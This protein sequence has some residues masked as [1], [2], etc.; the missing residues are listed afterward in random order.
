MDKQMEKR[1]KELMKEPIAIVPYDPQWA[2]RYADL[3][4]QLKRMIPRMLAQRITHIGSTAVPGLRSKPVVDVQVEVSDLEAV[5][6]ELAPRMEEAGYEFIWRPTMGDE[7]PFYAWFI[8]R[9]ASGE[10]M[11]HVHM[12]EP[13]QASVDRIVFRDYLR[14]HPE[15]VEVYASL[16]E[17]L[18][19]TFKRDRQA[20]TRGKTD[21]VNATLQK[22]RQEKFK[23]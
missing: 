17:D 3:E 20:Y 9:D 10:R 21:Y 5:R 6:N 4:T 18:A 2:V 7:A 1:I 12:V 16:K 23:R 15:E 11:A 8:L 13:G 22:A 14:N 19:Q